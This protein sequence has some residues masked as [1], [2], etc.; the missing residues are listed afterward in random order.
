MCFYVLGA[1]AAS[2]SHGGVAQ[3]GRCPGKP[4]GADWPSG[5][6]GMSLVWVVCALLLQLSLDC[7]WHSSGRD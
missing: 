7:T 6:P 1:A 2:P 5:A 3:C 4:S